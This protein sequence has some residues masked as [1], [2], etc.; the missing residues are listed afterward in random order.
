MGSSHTHAHTHART[1]T[2]THTHTHTRCLRACG[3]WGRLLRRHGQHRCGAPVSP[4][5]ST[6]DTPAT[7]RHPRARA[8]RGDTRATPVTHA[9]PGA[10]RPPIAWR[11]AKTREARSRHRHTPCRRPADRPLCAGPCKDTDTRSNSCVS[12]APGRPTPCGPQVSAPAARDAHRARHR[13]RPAAHPSQ[14][15][16]SAPRRARHR[17]RTGPSRGCPGSREAAARGAGRGAAAR[18]GRAGLGVAEGPARAAATCGEKRQ[19]LMYGP[20]KL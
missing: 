15:Q 8:R 19:L 20:K 12:K 4:S 9:R 5:P 7:R 10:A 1:H 14:P 13:S 3:V 6:R 18:L 11:G 2:H 16:V 17:S